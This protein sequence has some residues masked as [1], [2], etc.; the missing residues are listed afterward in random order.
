MEY[1]S[2]PLSLNKLK[3]LDKTTSM[4]DMS[5]LNFSGDATSKKRSSFLFIRN[6]NLDIPLSFKK[7]EYI[8]KEEFLLMYIQG[9]IDITSS[10]IASSWIDILLYPYEVDVG[11]NCILTKDEII[12]FIDTHS[13]LIQEV[14]QLIASFPVYS[15]YVFYEERDKTKEEDLESM[16]FEST[17]YDKINLS[18]LANLTADDD[19]LLLIRPR[20]D[21]KPMFYTKYFHKDNRGMYTVLANL[22][23]LGLLNVMMGSSAQ[24]DQFINGIEEMLTI[25][26]GDTNA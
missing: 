7:C 10:V 20:S 9:D 14:Y 17:D 24:H 2:L 18:N 8:D 1:Y 16:E 4:I 3:D 15:M 25:T 12:L 13:S 19:F 21:I 5:D 11:P 26:G 6:T 23:Y 22:P